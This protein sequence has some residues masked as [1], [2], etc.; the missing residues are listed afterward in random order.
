[1]GLTDYQIVLRSRVD[2]SVK[3]IFS[4]E[5]VD[6]FTYERILNDIS[7]LSLELEGNDTLHGQFLLD[8]MVEIE[9]RHPID[10]VFR[11]EGTYFVRFIQRFVEE[12]RDRLVIGGRSLEDLLRRRIIDPDD[13]PLSVGGYTILAGPADDLMRYVALH[14]LGLQA[15]VLRQAPDFVVNT[16][17]SI[18]GPVGDRLRH[19]NLFE[20]WQNFSDKGSVDFRLVRTTGRQIETEIGRFGQDLTYATNYGYRQMVLLQPEQGNLIDPSLTTDRT[21]EVNV[22]YALGQGP[23]DRRLV[24]KVTHERLLDSPWNRCEIAEDFRNLDRS[25]G[26][27]LITAGTGVLEDASKELE[28]FTFVLDPTAPGSVYRV[29]WDLGDRISVL[30][31]PFAGDFR[32]RGL[33]V[34]VTPED[35]DIDVEVAHA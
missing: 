32:I 14:N 15:N 33:T 34:T 2:G 7:K 35:E 22:V 31:G 20:V 4:A 3:S 28:E 26:Q 25:A 13:D 23:G 6:R 1:M 17:G 30:W 5:Q 18:G 10:Q 29:N 21:E 27:N 24:A 8:D 11:V 9:R 12:G 19:E 16:V